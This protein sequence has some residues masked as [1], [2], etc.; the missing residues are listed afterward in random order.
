MQR[1]SGKGRQW[2]EA[3]ARAVLGEAERSGLSLYSYARLRGW[4]P[5]RLYWWRDRLTV[6]VAQGVQFVPVRVTEHEED[7]D[8]P[9]APMFEVRLPGGLAVLVAPRF[10]AHELRRLLMALGEGTAC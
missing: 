5:Q 4:A 7:R 2:S 8:T 3:Q 10:N 1:G 6:G 9:A